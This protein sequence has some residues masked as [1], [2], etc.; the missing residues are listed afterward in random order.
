MPFVSIIIPCYNEQ[1]TI[2]VLLDAIFQQ[3]YPSSEME[4]IIV[5]GMSTDK[6]RQVI[7]EY[8][9]EHPDLAIRMLDNHRR[10]IP[11]ALNLG[12]DAARGQYVVRLDAHS[13]PEKDY[14]ERCVMDLTAGLGDNVGGMWLIRPGG[15]GWMAASIAA[16]AAHPLGV[17]DAYYRHTPKTGPVDTVPFGA[18]RRDLIDKIGKFNE[19][20][21]ANEDYE[22][23]TRI[24]KSGGRIWMDAQ[25][26][27]TYFARATLGGLARQYW[28]YGFYKFEM[29]RRYP[30]TLRW[31]QALPPLFVLGVFLGMVMSPFLS[32]ARFALVIVLGLYFLILG[33]GAI[34]AAIRLRDPRALVGV[35]LAIACMHFCWG[36]GFLWSIKRSLLQNRQ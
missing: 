30:E 7:A 22:F 14:V 16:A 35:P 11:S 29:L 33:V 2:R 10:T 23:N 8:Q 31:R 1:N 26:R 3:T 27:S 28:R 25:I 6:T 13:V 15:E 4:V 32:L 36:A 9:N 19:H 17:G 18:F 34:P 21:I 12:L 5:D 20:L 24:R